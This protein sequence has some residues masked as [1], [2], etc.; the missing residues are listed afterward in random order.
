[1]TNREFFEKV[2]NG[3][4]ITEE[5]REFA[6]KGIQK[7]NDRNSNRKLSKAEQKRRE[8]NEQF[9]EKFLEYIVNHEVATAKELGEQF[10]V[11]TQKASAIAKMLEK[12]GKV[13]VTNVI[14]NK[15][16]VK[17]YTK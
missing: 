7:L 15:R 2:V 3:N 1:M 9:A 5:M 13:K 12:N 14:V 17:G 11:S 8:E 6:K 10:E 4:E 16:V